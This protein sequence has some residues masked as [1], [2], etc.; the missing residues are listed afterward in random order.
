MLFINCLDES[1]AK[2]ELRPPPKDTYIE[3]TEKFIAKMIK[4]N[5]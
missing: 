2:L 3:D 1:L 5:K 4:R